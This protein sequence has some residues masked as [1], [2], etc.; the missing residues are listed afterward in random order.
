[1]LS[2]IKAKHV[3]K[4]LPFIVFHL[5]LHYISDNT[6][7]VIK[8]IILERPCPMFLQLLAH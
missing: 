4:Y 3:S 2:N 7:V 5:L 8:C 6:S 1:M